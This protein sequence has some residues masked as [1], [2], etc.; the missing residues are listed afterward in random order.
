MIQTATDN[1]T[2]LLTTE[3]V[4]DRLLADPKLRRMATLCV[5]P[6]V[7]HGGAWRF[8]RADLDDWIRRRSKQS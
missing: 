2:E 6:A 8:R 3:Q 7:R 5:L 4:M 1:Q